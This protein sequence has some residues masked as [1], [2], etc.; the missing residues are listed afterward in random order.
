MVVLKNTVGPVVWSRHYN[1]CGGDGGGDGAQ[2]YCAQNCTR[3]SR[4]ARE[5]AYD[6][7]LP[8]RGWVVPPKGW[9]DTQVEA[10]DT[11]WAIREV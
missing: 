9:T 11:L 10:D 8:L 4:A 7:R 6:D 5:A 2:G 1:T 3:V